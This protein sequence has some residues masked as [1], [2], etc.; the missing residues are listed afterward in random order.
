MA[1]SSCGSEPPA[2]TADRVQETETSGFL[3]GPLAEQD[4][5]ILTDVWDT[6]ITQTGEWDA[7]A[8]EL[9]DTLGKRF[10]AVRVF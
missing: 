7:P 3:W 2:H 6:S 5:A 8:E 4:T 9:G 10:H 1:S